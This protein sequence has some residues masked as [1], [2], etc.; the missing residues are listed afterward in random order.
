MFCFLCTF[1]FLLNLFLYLTAPRTAT[2]RVTVTPWRGWPAWWPAC[3]RWPAMLVVNTPSMVVSMV[4][5]TRT[6]HMVTRLARAGWRKGEIVKAVGPV[7]FYG[8]HWHWASDGALYRQ[9]GLLKL[10]GLCFIFCFLVHPCFPTCLFLPLVSL[11]SCFSSWWILSSF[12]LSCASRATT[13]AFSWEISSPGL[14]PALQSAHLVGESCENIK[15]YKLSWHKNQ[16]QTFLDHS[17]LG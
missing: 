2:A 7:N 11:L 8:L 17:S 1:L 4:S 12:S 10:H 3:T 13:W 14:W 5:S 9:L 16:Q 6:P 15:I